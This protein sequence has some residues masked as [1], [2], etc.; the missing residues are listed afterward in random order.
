[1][2]HLDLGPDEGGAGCE[3]LVTAMT[4]VDLPTVADHVGLADDRPGNPSK[5]SHVYR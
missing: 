1:M 4:F 5:V 2:T 3:N